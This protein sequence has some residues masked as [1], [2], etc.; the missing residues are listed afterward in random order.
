MY[1][2]QKRRLWLSILAYNGIYYHLRFIS[3][4]ALRSV[5]SIQHLFC[6]FHAV[7][8]G[9]AP[10]LSAAALKLSYVHISSMLTS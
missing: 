5:A 7:L 8:L 1:F 9:N 6:I 4:Q 10:L 2:I 3:N